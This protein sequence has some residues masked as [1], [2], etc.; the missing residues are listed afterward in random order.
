[1]PTSA[2]ICKRK[3]NVLPIQWEKG[4]INHILKC[5]LCVW[6]NLPFDRENVCDNPFISDHTHYRH[7]AVA[8][9]K[10]NHKC[11]ICATCC[12]LP[13]R[14][15]K[16]S[17]L[18]RNLVVRVYQEYLH[19]VYIACVVMASYRVCKYCTYNILVALCANII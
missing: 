5:A 11:A 14:T 12:S 6:I 4:M 2:Y 1:M 7:H 18:C 17:S 9:F 8:A 19:Y 13:Y 3:I 10:K 16:G 15:F